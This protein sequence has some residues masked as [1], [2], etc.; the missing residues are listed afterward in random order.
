MRSDV[1]V[2]PAAFL[3]RLRRV[4]PAS[5]WDAIVNTFTQPKPTTFRVNTLKASAPDV[6]QRLTAHGLLVEP[7][8]WYR[9]AFLV[10][11][12]SL[13]ELQDTALYRSGA[14][15]VQSL[16]SMLPPLVLDP[17]PGETVLDLTAAPGSKT[18]QIACLMRGEG[19]I[20]A[21]DNHRIRGYKLRANIA[22]QG[23]R[24][25]E[26]TLRDG[27]SF[28]RQQP[29][30][31]DRVLVDAP[32]S[33]EGR[34]LVHEPGS[35]RYWKPRKIAEMA[36]KQRRLLVSAIQA[37]RPGGVVVYST[38]TFA[39]EENEAVIDWALT[40]GVRHL[41]RFERCL[42]PVEVETV[43]LDCPNRLA[44]LTS[45]D[46]AAFHPSL[47]RAVRIAP[48]ALMEG[49]FIARLRK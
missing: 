4:V 20:V 14:I 19:R 38:C 15:Y 3:E 39:P 25:V 49:F 16:S 7:V 8:P 35:F 47:A 43:A 48:T 33:A 36:R 37:V 34:F 5:R 2:L 9:D 46:G 41:S 17:Q 45:W 11:R 31:F 27:G 23:A 24:N 44:G 29:E 32:C 21:N 40:T 12:G 13:R 28:G 42:T 18:T 1:R 10:R 22:Q 26:V 30:A 6:R